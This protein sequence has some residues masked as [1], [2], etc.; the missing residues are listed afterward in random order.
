L[1]VLSHLP[2]DTV[3]ELPVVLRHSDEIGRTGRHSGEALRCGSP[4]TSS[5]SITRADVAVSRP[6][7][8][9]ELQRANN[10]P[11]ERRGHGCT[12]SGF[13]ACCPQQSQLCGLQ[14]DDLTG[15]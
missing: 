13:T 11:H 1:E 6:I 10:Q 8:R 7:E 9:G 12:R 5:R 3:K 4:R 2:R 15:S 14:F